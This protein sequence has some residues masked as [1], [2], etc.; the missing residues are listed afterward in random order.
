M[1]PA[2]STPPT[3]P[4]SLFE[5]PLPCT[6][7][8][9]EDNY[10]FLSSPLLNNKQQVRSATTRTQFPTRQNKLSVS[11]IKE[12]DTTLLQLLL[13]PSRS[14]P[15]SYVAKQDTKIFGEPDSSKRKK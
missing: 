2:A 5:M 14:L 6:A 13:S 1:Q 10:S 15:L 7:S 9:G 12:I 8:S 11:K 4:S 3:P